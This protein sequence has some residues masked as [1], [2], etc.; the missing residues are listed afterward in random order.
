MKRTNASV[1]LRALLSF[2]LYAASRKLINCCNP[3]LRTRNLTYPQYLVLLV[4]WE[5]DGQTV[6]EIGQKLYL[7][8]GTLTPMIKKMEKAGLVERRRCQEDERSVRV[9]LT[10]KGKALE[11]E[12]HDIPLQVAEQITLPEEDAEQLYSTLYKLINNL[13]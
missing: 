2:P 8:S 3:L 6:G 5:E 7:D 9:S 4:L 12:L 10:E 11:E 13:D 1:S